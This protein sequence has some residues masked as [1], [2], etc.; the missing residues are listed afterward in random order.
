MT[1]IKVTLLRPKV[2][3]GHPLEQLDTRIFRACDIR[4]RVP[5]QINVEVAFAVG[6][7]LGRWY[8][9]AKVG[10]G[11]DTRVSSAA[12]ADAL[13]AGFLTS[14]C[15]TFDLGFCPTE[16]V[17][18][19]VGIERIHLG[20][21]VTASHNPEPDNGFK[22]FKA[23]G[24]QE[25]IAHLMDRLRV[26]LLEN[27]RGQTASAAKAPIALSLINEFVEHIAEPLDLKWTKGPLALNGLNGTASLVATPLA[28]RLAL[29]VR[30]IRG[31]HAG[32]PVAG[33][34]PLKPP[35]AAEMSAFVRASRTG[36]GVAWDGDADRCVFFDAAGALV[37]NAYVMAM[38]AD[39]FLKNA[40]AAGV[41]YDP[42]LV[43]SIQKT[44]TRHRSHGVRVAT[45]SS[46]MR[47]AMH[48]TGAVYGGE[49][50]AHH[51][52]GRLGG[53]DSGMLAWVT[54]LQIIE[55]SDQTLC[56]LASAYRQ[57]V[58]VLP[59]LSLKVD[60][61]EAMILDLDQALLKGKA[62]LEVEGG[63]ATF[64]VETHRTYQ[65]ASGVRFSLNPSTTEAVMRFNFESD[66]DPQH[67]LEQSEEILKVLLRHTDSDE[68]SLP[69]LALA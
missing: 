15:E 51:Y 7:L 28:E 5:E 67:L 24:D 55:H 42:K 16:I 65:L 13:I 49:S 64:G 57:E 52:F 4:G 12:L 36:V 20:V 3:Q 9:Q 29:D 6:R 22:I 66:G 61:P 33:P 69:V 46:H 31:E 56:E 37:P 47:A 59:E 62:C 35:L 23:H 8:P 58:A 44:V 14:G 19:G 32:L 26:A 40:G 45:G 30:W 39:H 1:P 38:M 43:L 34:D 10:V 21:M 27:P 17:A 2:H 63:K 53:I 25:P 54:M 18:F 11:R 60:H 50:S 41:V 48:H 68:T